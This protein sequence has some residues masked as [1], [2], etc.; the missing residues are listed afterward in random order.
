MTILSRIRCLFHLS[1]WDELGKLSMQIWG[2]LE[3]QQHEEIAP[4][5]VKASVD[6]QDWDTASEC[7]S[8]RPTHN[9]GSSLTRLVGDV[10][11]TVL[12]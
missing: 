10:S 11:P 1:E 4:M 5:L 2:R 12:H 3:K 6:M 9:H 8:D 7:V